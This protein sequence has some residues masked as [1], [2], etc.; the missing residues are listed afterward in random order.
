MHSNL[1]IKDLPIAEELDSR[2][3]SAVRDRKS[4]V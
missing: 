1:M 4:V 2:A 3:M